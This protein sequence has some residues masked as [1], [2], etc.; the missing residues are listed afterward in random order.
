MNV[1]VV[2]TN[3]AERLLEFLDAWDPWPW[4]RILVIEDGPERTIEA[5]AAAAVELEEADSQ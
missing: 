4:D 5:P 1:L 3:R 2:P